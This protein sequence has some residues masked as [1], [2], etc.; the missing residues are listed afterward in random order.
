MSLYNGLKIILCWPF[1][2]VYAP[3]KFSFGLFAK[4]Y[5]R[6]KQKLFAKVIIIR[7]SFNS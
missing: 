4:V 1:A 2:K 5:A 6:E 7:E 3:E